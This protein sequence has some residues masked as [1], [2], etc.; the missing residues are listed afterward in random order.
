MAEVAHI[1][2]DNSVTVGDMFAKCNQYGKVAL[3]EHM[4]EVSHS[5]RVV[6]IGDSLHKVF[7]IKLIINVLLSFSFVSYR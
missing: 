5:N 7:L 4:F 2:L 1:K 6:I 3:E